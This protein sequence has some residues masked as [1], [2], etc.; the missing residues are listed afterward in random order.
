MNDSRMCMNSLLTSSIDKFN[1]GMKG[2]T[3][4]N[5]VEFKD[6]V[7]NKEGKIE[8]AILVDRLTNKEFKVKAKV[9]V[10][11]TGIFADELRIK[12]KPDAL[13]RITGARG[14]HLMFKSSIVPKDHGII[15]PKTK[16]GRLLFVI[17]YLGHSMVGTTDEKCEITH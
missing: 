15:I 4:A 14:T 17:N 11:C 7:K 16:D 2:S 3:L 10:N 6:F 1:P 5:Y 13:P 12:D 9:V 8:G